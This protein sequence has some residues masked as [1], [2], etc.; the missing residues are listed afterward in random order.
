MN[1]VTNKDYTLKLLEEIINIPSP[2]GYC[3]NV[4]SHIEKVANEFQ[5]KFEKTKRK[6]NN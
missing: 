1:I 4:M 3:N 6:R 5:F 2:T